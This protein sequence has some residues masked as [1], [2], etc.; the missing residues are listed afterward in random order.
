MRDSDV[1]KVVKTWL[2]QEYS[3]DASTR[4]VEEMG[5]WNGSVRVDIAVING[6]LHGLELKSAKDTL[7]RLQNQAN[8]YN[9]VFDR[10]TLVADA[11]HID[12]A[13][14]MI[15]EWWGLMSVSMDEHG[16]ASLSLLRQGVQNSGLNKLQIARL[17]W[18]A[19]IIAIL[20]RR[21]LAHGFRS[22]PSEVL[23][24]RLAN[25]LTLNELT[26]E[27]RSVLKSRQNWLG[28][29]IGDETEMTICRNRHPRCAIS[30]TGGAGSNLPDPI[31]PPTIC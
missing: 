1:R 29:S 31:V 2:E 3:N 4:I 14:G 13:V 24:S 26:F 25:E 12:K 8:L 19:E 20:D 10:V 6:K 21:E 7:Q 5:V 17:L 15:P 22:K 23:A 28:Q 18:K 9:Q 16:I 27:V 30:G 11:R